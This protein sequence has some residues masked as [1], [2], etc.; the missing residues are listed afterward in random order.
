MAREIINRVQKLRKKQGLQVNDDIAVFLG[1]EGD[2][3]SKAV[4][5]EN[6]M[7]RQAVKKPVYLLTE[8]Q[9][10]LKT[11]VEETFEVDNETLKV[12]IT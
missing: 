1:L 6:S 7:I 9:A 8:K 2:V 4:K 5:T 12:V 3:L 11:I 10:H